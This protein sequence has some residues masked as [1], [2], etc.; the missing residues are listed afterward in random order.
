MA[1]DA[2]P[3][4][5][6]VAGVDPA[7]AG[8]LAVFGSTELIV[9]ERMDAL[10]EEAAEVAVDFTTARGALENLRW[11]AD[12]GVHAVVGTTGIH[13]SEISE[14]GGMFSRGTA[15]CVMAP[16][17]AIG[18]VLMMSMAALAAPYMQGV[19]IVELHHDGK[20]DAPSGTALATAERLRE[21]RESAGKGAFK[22]GPAGSE[23]LP[24]ARGAPASGGV[25]VHA[26]RLPGLVSH[27]EVVM[28][29][30]GQSLTIRHDSYDRSSFMPG[31]LMAIKAVAHRPG[32]TVGLEALL[33]L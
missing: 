23:V 16:N 20:R 7:C 31:V 17:F 8:K 15:N 1:V 18:A 5:E 27:Q 26:V 13:D 2:E 29:A 25:H 33:G 24:G 14:V 6:L 9:A 3:G 19:E 10:S 12:N 22:D 11:C 21:A 32:L 30:A 28:G 4:L